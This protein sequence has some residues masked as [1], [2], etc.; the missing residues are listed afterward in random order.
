MFDRGLTAGSSGNLSARLPD[1]FLMT[2]TNSCLGFLE[3]AR[4]SKLDPLGGACGG[5]SADQGGAAAPRAL[6]RAAAGGGVVHLHSTYATA[7]SCLADTD[8]EDAIPPITPYVVMRVGRVPLIPYTRPGSAEVAPL[9]AAKARARRRR[10]SSPTTGRWSRRASFRDAVFAAEE[11]EET[12]K[13]VLLTRG[14][15]VRRLSAAAVAALRDDRGPLPMRALI[16]R[17]AGAS[18]AADGRVLGE[19]GARLVVF[20]CAMQGD[21][22]AESAWLARKTVALRIFRDAEGR[23]NRSL[24]DT[25]GAALV[26]SQFT[27]AAETRGNRPGFSTAAEPEAGRRLYEHFARQ[28]EGHGVAV[29]TG[30]LRRG[31]ARGAGERRPGDDLARHRGAVRAAEGRQPRT[32]PFRAPLSTPLRVGAAR[33]R[34]PRSPPRDDRGPRSRSRQRE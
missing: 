30:A 9:I 8:P 27:L 10:C 19:I 24:L 22:E 3:P 20:V 21:G 17:A 28:V 13:L 6:R 26:V 14:M 23:M 18:V 25:G 15:K 11:L 12:A 4:L 33:P 31:H 34:S 1:G 29:A 5:R 7:L 32:R 16:Q 2:P